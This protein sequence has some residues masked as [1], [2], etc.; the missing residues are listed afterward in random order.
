MTLRDLIQSVAARPALPLA[1]FFALPLVSYLAGRIHGP[2]RGGESPWRYVYAVVVYLVCLSGMFALVLVGYALYFTN[3]N[4]LDVNALV[5]IL[6]VVSMIATLVVMSRNVDFDAVPGFDRLSGLM[7]MAGLAFAI[8]LGVQKTRLW[9]LFGGS[10]FLLFVIA[11][12]LLVVLQG[13]AH[14]AFGKRP[15]QEN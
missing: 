7:I 14:V 3:E 9:I 8:A 1:F 10:I 4:L 15:P 11:I 13:A 2:G 6:P 5:Y 12:V